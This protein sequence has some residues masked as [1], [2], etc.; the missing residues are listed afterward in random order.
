MMEV[1]CGSSGEEE[2][3]KGYFNPLHVPP[4]TQLNMRVIVVSIHS[5]LTA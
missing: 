5:I 1:V 4:R 2:G 3:V